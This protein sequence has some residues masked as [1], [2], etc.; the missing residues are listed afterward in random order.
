MSGSLRLGTFA[1]IGVFVHWTFFLLIAWVALGALFAG[2]T[3]DEV[4]GTIAL[5]LAVFVCVVLHEFGHAL[6][7]RCF[8][9]GTRDVTLLPI[10]GVA[11]LKQIPERPEEELVVAIAG[12]LVNVLIVALLLPVALLLDAPA[13]S[14][15]ALPG[16]RHFVADLI[17]VNIGLVA[18]NMIPA[19]PMDGGRV[20]RATLAMFIDR[21]QATRFA[22]MLGQAFA[23]LFGLVG[24]F[25]NPLLL[26]VAVFV[27]LGAHAEAHGVERRWITRGI[28]AR[29]AMVRRFDTLS[30]DDRVA[31]AVDHLISGWQTDFPVVR[32]GRVIGLLGREEILRAVAEGRRDLRVSSLARPSHA[33]HPTD[34]L[35]DVLALMEREE[36]RSVPVVDNGR[37]IG[38]M[39]LENLGEW[40]MLHSQSGR[41]APPRLWARARDKAATA[42]RTNGAATP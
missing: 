21:V 29:D 37:C 20:L 11:R 32:D 3:L 4:A 15:L 8:G 30:P 41:T 25:M 26:L 22:A 9:I 27:F 38:M 34:S 5:V 16:G 24:L 39:S 35:E 6:A 33:V 19:F 17:A 36:L 14:L 1:G 18:F 10:G 40:L 7:A 13:T 12:P 2:A 28:P 42:P 23:V 31:T